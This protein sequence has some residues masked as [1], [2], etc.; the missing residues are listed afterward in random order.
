MGVKTRNVASSQ[1]QTIIVLKR[2]VISVFLTIS[3]STVNKAVEN[4]R[5]IKYCT[6]LVNKTVDKYGIKMK[7]L[8]IIER[9]KDF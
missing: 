4:F 6:Q 3:P 9:I 7:K 2:H 8:A 5:L 1:C